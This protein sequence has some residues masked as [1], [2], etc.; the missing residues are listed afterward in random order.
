MLRVIFTHLYV[1][2]M[3]IIVI[4]TSNILANRYGDDIVNSLKNMVS[5][6]DSGVNEMQESVKDWNKHMLD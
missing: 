4:T 6:A 5:T 2:V 1:I 3:A